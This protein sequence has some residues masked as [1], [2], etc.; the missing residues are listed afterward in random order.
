MQI[1][2]ENGGYKI[3]FNASIRECEGEKA[4]EKMKEKIA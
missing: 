4:G 2:G 1:T 3:Q